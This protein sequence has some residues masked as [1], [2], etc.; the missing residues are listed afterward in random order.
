MGRIVRPVRFGSEDG[1][2]WVAADAAIDTGSTHCQIPESVAAQLHARVHRR[3]RVRLAD[4][5]MIERDIVI[6]LLDLDPAL[7]PLQT[8]AVVGGEGSP[9]LIGVVPLEQMGVGLDPS[10]DRLI[11]VIDDL[12]GMTEWRTV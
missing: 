2:V 4:G 7:A 9:F 10:G 1:S 8:L 11:P 6:V 12:L 5:R 3:S